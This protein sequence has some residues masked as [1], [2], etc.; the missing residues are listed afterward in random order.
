MIVKQVLADTDLG[1][2]GGKDGF[3]PWGEAGQFK[4]MVA[5]LAFAKIISNIIGVLTIVAGL[6]FIFQLISSAIGIMSASGDPKKL[7]TSSASIKNAIIGLVVV[8]AAYALMSLLGKLLGFEFL[9][10]VDS[11]KKLGPAS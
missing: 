7:E 6:W 5:S 9:N 3:G 10:I 11:I 2:I 1:P 4:I 8:V